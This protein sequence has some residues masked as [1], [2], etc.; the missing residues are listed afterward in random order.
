[1][2]L[3]MKKILGLLPSLLTLLALAGCCANNVCLCNDTLADALFFK[4]NYTSHRQYSGARP[5]SFSANDVDTI[6]VYRTTRPPTDTKDTLSFVRTTDSVTIARLAIPR[7]G[8][9]GD[10]IISDT[11]RIT[12]TNG[13]TT[14]LIDQDLLVINNA[15]PFASTSTTKLSGYNYRIGIIRNASKRRK[16]LAIYYLTSIA[17]SGHY[18]ANGC[19]TCYQN[20]GKAYTLTPKSFPST[21]VNAADSAGGRRVVRLPFVPR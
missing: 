18:D 5:I 3:P 4:I 8:F 1:M 19:C 11:I 20:T 12:N 7:R 16:P 2:L 17:L 15:S 14:R 10:T 9:P 21:A 6:R 13:S